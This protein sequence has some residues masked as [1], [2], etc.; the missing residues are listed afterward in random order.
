MNMELHIPASRLERR[1]RLL[2]RAYPP[3]YRADRGEEMLGTLLEATPDGQHWPSALDSWS[4]LA[5]GLRARRAGNRQLGPATS[6]RQAVILGL[7]LYLSLA[8]AELL[9][10]DPLTRAHGTPMLA[11]LLLAAT[12]LAIWAGR[13]TLMVTSVAATLAVLAYYWYSYWA[14]AGIRQ[15]PFQLVINWFLPVV[16]LLLAM[17]ALV[18][19]T[20]IGG[21]LPRSWLLLA[22]APPLAMIVA[23]TLPVLLRPSPAPNWAW[24]LLPDVFMLLAIPALAWLATDA[25]PALGVAL[26]YFV[27]QAVP[28]AATMQLYIATRQPVAS[29][30]QWNGTNIGKLALAAALTVALARLLRRRTRPHPR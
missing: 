5:G 29:L 21:R 22:G 25:R 30:V 1:A 16:P 6:L 28:L 24:T 3:A 8:S 27:S 26:A 12:V 11:G 23:R 17:L 9:M 13:R 19:L 10:P 20:R 14:F 18:R 15:P 7:A 4:L 2:L